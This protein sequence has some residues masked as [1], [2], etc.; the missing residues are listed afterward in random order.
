[1][2]ETKETKEE[3]FNADNLWVLA[4]DAIDSVET[5]SEQRKKDITNL[6]WYE[7]EMRIK[8]GELIN[9]NFNGIVR[10][11]KSTAAQAVCWKIKMLIEKYHGVKRP[12]SNANI[13]RDQNEY[14]RLVKRR[15]EAYK[16]ECDVI[17]EWSEMELAGYNSTIEEKFLKQFSD[18]QAGRYYHRIACSPHDTTDK[19]S[20]I[21]LQTVP[22]SRRDG[23]VLCLLSYR[24]SNGDVSQPVLL[25]HV[26]IDVNEVMKAKWYKEYLRKK[27]E[28]WVLMN[29]HNVKS[30]RELEY[31]QIILATYAKMSTIAKYGLNKKKH[32]KIA[33]QEEAD[34]H[35]VWFSILGDRDVLETLEGL[36]ELTELV[37]TTEQQV[38]AMNTK[39]RKELTK[40]KQKSKPTEEYSDVLRAYLKELKASLGSMLLRQSTLSDLWHQYQL[41]DEK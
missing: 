8:N 21:L 10:S 32:F 9:L 29:K 35:G 36:G 1:M 2:S 22:G 41:I 14:S 39:E 28:K 27:E 11:G 12:M 40:T 33:L 7:I 25:G 4:M 38:L 6:F 16:H 13:T 15:P 17:D 19:N 34:K 30:P 24:L 31:A 18:V 5:Q 26:I 37:H 20:D 3:Q 23:R